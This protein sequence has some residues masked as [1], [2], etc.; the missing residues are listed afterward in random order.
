M[1]AAATWRSGI[2]ARPIDIADRICGLLA[3]VMLVLMVAGPWVMASTPPDGAGGEAAT[4]R[5]RADG[6]PVADPGEIMVAGYAGAPFYYRSNLRL[7][8]PDDT[9]VELKRLG[10]D[11]DALYFPI[12]GGIRSVQWFSFIGLMIDFLHN[13]AIARL[14]KGSH[15]RRIANGII[16]EVEAVGRIAGK[17]AP[18]RVKLTDVFERMEFT[19]GHNVLLL[20][21][22]VQLGYVT[23]R[24]RPYF[25]LG[26][27]FALPHVE[28]WFPGDT[29]AKRTNEYQLAGP[30]AQFVAGLEIRTGRMS[31]FLEYKFTWAWI[32]GALTGD[33]SWMN[34]NMPGDLLRQL[35]RWW[36]G[37]E[38]ALGRISTT[39]AAHQFVGGAGYWWQRGAKTR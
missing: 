9:D 14:G 17:P 1:L 15:G 22:M 26:G 5:D 27:G 10:W 21:P 37:A 34:F 12:D 35:K 6:L 23:P 11:G 20:T 7:T 3:A 33:Q 18:P 36:S 38:P 2:G 4:A 32:R 19:H 28:V 25:G 30:A 13:K 39:L 24:L 31:Y 8:R 29:N 16:D